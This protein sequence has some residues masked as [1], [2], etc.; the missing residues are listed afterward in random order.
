MGFEQTV[1]AEDESDFQYLFAQDL[2][3]LPNMHVEVDNDGPYSDTEIIPASTVPSDNRKGPLRSLEND[4]SGALFDSC[5]VLENT[6]SGNDEY[7]WQLPKLKI[8][9]KGEAISQSLASLINTA[10]TSQC[11][12]DGIV[13][14][15][16][17]P[18]NCDKLAPPLI[19]GEIWNEIHKKAQAFRD[20]Q[21]LIASGMIPIIKLASLLKDQIKSNEQAKTMFSDSITLFGQAQYN[22]S[23][24]QRYMIRPFLKK[25]YSNLCNLNT[26]IT[27]SLFGD[28][29]QKEIKKCD[30]SLSVA[31]DQYG[32]YGPQRFRGRVRGRG[33]SSRGY[34]NYGN[35][36]YGNYQGGWG[37]NR[38][39]PYGR[40]PV[41]YRYPTQYQIPKKAKKP[42]TSTEDVVS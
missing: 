33:M 42:T 18:S 3:N 24:R 8:P 22:L 11:E 20:I 2:S 7:F 14:K 17:L 31:K 34:G 41:Q 12:T 16:K 32:S 26:P 9:E 15:Y 36:G 19:N 5:S 27:T 1:S 4:I 30:T 40:Q 6:D 28:D 23:I 21:G 25:K 38:F 35:Y 10:C 37:Y 29:V 39:Q 13:S